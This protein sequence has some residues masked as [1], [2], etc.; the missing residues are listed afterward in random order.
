VQGRLRNEHLTATIQT[1]CAHCGRPFQLEVD[2]ELKYRLEDE[3]IQPLVF[4]PGV[5]WST[6]SQPN[7]ID[8]Y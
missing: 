1:S 2:S 4:L 8:G 7:I 5:D 6:F 3:T